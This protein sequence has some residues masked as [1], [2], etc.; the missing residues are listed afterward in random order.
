MSDS[1]KLLRQIARA[2]A[3]FAP[4]LTDRDVDRLVQGA[5]Q[6][7]QRRKT[8]VRAALATT[9]VAAAVL[10]A[11]HFIPA[12]RSSPVSPPPIAASAASAGSALRLAD[13][14]TATPTG[15]GSTLAV[16]GES[17]QRVE[18][19]L[20]RGGARFEV[21]RSPDRA[22]SVQAGDV[23]VTVLG[24]I[25]TVERVADRIGVTVERGTVRVDWKVGT[26]ELHR[27]ES[28]WFPPLMV[29]SGGAPTEPAP[30]PVPVLPSR[31][32]RDPVRTSARSSSAVPAGSVGARAETAEQLL[33]A[34][35]GER[36]AG[37]PAEGA[38]ILQRLLR[39]HGHDARAPLAAFTLG[40]LLLRELNRPREAAAAF[41]EVRALA[42]GG[43]FAEDAL[44]RE[45]EAWRR[46]GE[47]DRARIRAKEYLKLYPDGRRVEAIKRLGEL[48]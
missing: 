45:I 36:L 10:V 11:V 32:E 17:A 41:A 35:D 12:H 38:A 39:E 21:V 15:P 2:G 48:D 3:G 33:A 7:R 1:Q 19:A 29:D 4:G 22:F 20:R 24:T 28:G 23:T 43:S 40:R 34:A 42:P 30:Q 6:R 9:T 26:R 47:G 14:S 16:L 31:R 37:H 46:A 13:G 27:G 8:R 18:V 25:F 44:A 5:A